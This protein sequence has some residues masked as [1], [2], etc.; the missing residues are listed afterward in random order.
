MGK[1]G[2]STGFLGGMVSRVQSPLVQVSQ[3]N[4]LSV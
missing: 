4:Q 1:G 2:V 3:F